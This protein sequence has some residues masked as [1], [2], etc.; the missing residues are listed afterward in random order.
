MG[1]FSGG[2]VF[3]VVGLIFVDIAEKGSTLKP[4]Y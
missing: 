1:E 4:T 3:F 2:N